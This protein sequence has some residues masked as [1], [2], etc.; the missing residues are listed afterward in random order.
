MGNA[1]NTSEYMMVIVEKPFMPLMGNT[2]N[3]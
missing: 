1:Q 2:Q 3:T